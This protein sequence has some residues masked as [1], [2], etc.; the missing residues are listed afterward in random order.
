VLNVRLPVLVRRSRAKGSRRTAPPPLVPTEPCALVVTTLGAALVVSSISAA[1]GA[2]RPADCL[3]LP[4]RWTYPRQ[5]PSSPAIARPQ[6]HAISILLGDDRNLSHL[7]SWICSGDARRDIRQKQRARSSVV[8]SPGESHGRC[9]FKRRCCNRHG[10][11]GSSD[12]RCGRGVLR[13]L[14]ATFRRQCR[15]S[16]RAVPRPSAAAA[17]F[18]SE[19]R[20]LRRPVIDTSA[21][22]QSSW[23][24]R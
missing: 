3:P 7:S 5:G 11:L 15:K 8:S 13:H 17:A 4:P 14:P 2:L 16:V 23:N 19:L 10:G 22:T 9:R 1:S 21:N 20:P 6:A 24:D 18:G 12:L